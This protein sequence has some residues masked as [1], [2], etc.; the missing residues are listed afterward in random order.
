MPK[1][2]TPITLLNTSHPTKH[3]F[4]IYSTFL[5]SPPLNA[6]SINSRS[7]ANPITWSE[8]KTR[9]YPI[10]TQS[11][12]PFSLTTSS[13]KKTSRYNLLS[14]T[15]NHKTCIIDNEYSFDEFNPTSLSNV[16]LLFEANHRCQSPI[17]PLPFS[18]TYTC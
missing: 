11:I 16:N 1:A 7:V 17:D 9:F 14:P 5:I 12:Y 8:P 4:I 15:P 18:H 2:P 6:A 10:L 3:S 13:I